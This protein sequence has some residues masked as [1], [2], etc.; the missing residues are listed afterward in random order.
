MKNNCLTL[1]GGLFVD[2]SSDFR[3][4]GAR[5]EIRQDQARRRLGVRDADDDV[6]CEGGK[7]L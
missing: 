1:L 3:C 2:G 4:F 7:L 5:K 6:A